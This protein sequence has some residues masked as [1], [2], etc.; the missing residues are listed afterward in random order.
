M[1]VNSKRCEANDKN[2]LQSDPTHVNVQSGHDKVPSVLDACHSRT[3]CLDDE[4][5]NIKADEED[6]KPARRDADEF[7]FQE[8][9]V[10]HAT[11][12]HVQEGIDPWN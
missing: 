8:E 2:L 9:E 4:G 5:E 12:G 6:A 11:E 7:L 10:D 3:G 1:K